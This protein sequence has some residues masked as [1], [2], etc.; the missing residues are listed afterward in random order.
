MSLTPNVK[1]KCEC[2][3]VCVC[4]CVPV[5]VSDCVSARVCVC[6]T[7]TMEF[8]MSCNVTAT[9][10]QCMSIHTPTHFLFTQP[11]C[12]SLAP[13]LPSFLLSFL[14]YFL[15]C[16]SFLLPFL[17]LF[18]SPSPSL[19]FP[20]TVVRHPQLPY[21]CYIISSHTWE[22]TILDQ[23]AYCYIKC[24]KQSS[25]QLHSYYFTA[26]FIAKPPHRLMKWLYNVIKHAE[27]LVC[28][29]CRCYTK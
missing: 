4:V 25:A 8:C 14:P 12:S 17:S 9:S 13:F 10:V 3:C 21:V 23:I 22:N 5:C 1:A 28:L 16:F 18:H 7:W 2:V 24:S 6:L 19:V 20:H 29:P 11:W 26:S 27:L 15:A